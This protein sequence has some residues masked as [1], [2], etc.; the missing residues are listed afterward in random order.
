MATLEHA[1]VWPSAA[2]EKAAVQR[3]KAKAKANAEAALDDRQ[4][5]EAALDRRQAKAAAI[6]QQT[7]QRATERAALLDGAATGQTMAEVRYLMGAGPDSTQRI[8][9][10][11]VIWY[12]TFYLTTGK[13]YQI[14]FGDGIH[15]SEVNQY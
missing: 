13:E 2:T 6:R 10:F 11:G 12:Y 9:G 1:V 8:T 4:L 15:V 14:V 5:A 3:A 7:A